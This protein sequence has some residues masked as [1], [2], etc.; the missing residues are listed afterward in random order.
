VGA[1]AARLGSS[2][3]A[4]ILTVNTW[5]TATFH[6]TNA[7]FQNGQ[8]GDADFRLEMAVPP[9]IYVRRVTVTREEAAATSTPR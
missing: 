5:A 9:E 1:R 4:R 3:Y 2:T 7:V 8:N 6:V